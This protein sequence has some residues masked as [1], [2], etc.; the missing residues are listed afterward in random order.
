MI[1]TMVDGDIQVLTCHLGGR[2]PE[3]RCH[4]AV[5]AA[6]SALLDHLASRF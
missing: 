2:D 5:G 3:E 4:T 6:L 1:G